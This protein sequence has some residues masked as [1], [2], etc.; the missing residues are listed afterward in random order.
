MAHNYNVERLE[1]T[2]SDT[3]TTPL[4]FFGCAAPPVAEAMHAGNAEPYTTEAQ[5][6][7]SARAGK[8]LLSA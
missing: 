6:Y 2:E 7:K 8:D 4:N 1:C 5:Q 3:I